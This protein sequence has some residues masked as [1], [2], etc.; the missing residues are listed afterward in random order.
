MTNISPD[1]DSSSEQ[2][3]A[4]KFTIL[5]ILYMLQMMCSRPEKAKTMSP[6]MEGDDDFADANT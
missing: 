2:K 4:L 6:V 1:Y 5:I 3:L